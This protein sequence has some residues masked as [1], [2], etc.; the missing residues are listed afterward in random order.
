MGK[1]LKIRRVESIV[2]EAIKD[3]LEA[4]HIIGDEV[5]EEVKPEAQLTS[6]KPPV[7]P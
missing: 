6:T 7:K 1:R 4:L 5:D 3:L 2:F